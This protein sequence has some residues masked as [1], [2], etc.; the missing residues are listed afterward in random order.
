MPG[1]RIGAMRPHR[2]PQ[3]SNAAVRHYHPVCIGPCTASTEPDIPPDQSWRTPMKNMILA[4]VAL[5]LGVGA[6]FAQGGPVGYQA[7][8]YGS[9]AFTDHSNEVATQLFNR[10]NSNQVAATSSTKG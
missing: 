5:S 4:A 1:K 9:R 8:I 3:K 2:H 7:P 10:S 6:A